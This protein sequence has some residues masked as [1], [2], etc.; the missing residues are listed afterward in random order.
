MQTGKVA[1]AEAPTVMEAAAPAVPTDFSQLSRTELTALVK[2]HG[3][4]KANAKKDVMVDALLNLHA[5]TVETEQPVAVV[6][7]APDA[8]IEPEVSP[9]L[10]QP[11]ARRWLSLSPR[12]PE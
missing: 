10:E 6:E 3:V 11:V 12:T 4:C 2:Q 7:T 1:M 5:S 8:A 9:D